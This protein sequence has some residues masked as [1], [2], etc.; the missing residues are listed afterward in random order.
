[1][2]SEGGEE[3]ER[4]IALEERARDLYIDEKASE[5]L[6]YILESVE[7]HRNCYDALLLKSR[8]LSVLNRY[9]EAFDAV[10]AAI[11]LNP[12]C[13]DGYMDKSGCYLETDQLDE[14]ESYARKAMQM[15]LSNPDP[16]RADL[17][18]AYETLYNILGYRG[19]SEEAA[20]VQAEAK[21]KGADWLA[22]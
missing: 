8:I 18:F 4:A 11:A 17:F 3:F 14:S 16:T 2:S 6:P 13:A 15:V 9:D 7:L 20:A 1:M 12:E 5:A 19:K 10:N 22:D 21:A